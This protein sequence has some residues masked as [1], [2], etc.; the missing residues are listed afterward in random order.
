[1]LGKLLKDEMKSYRFPMG[2]VFLAGLV[3]TIFM[4]IMCMLP[5]DS[6]I[7]EGI[8]ILVA[9]GYYYIILLIVTAA[10]V[11]VIIRFYTTMVSDRGYLT[12]TLPIKS[13]THIWAKLISGSIWRLIAM[14]VTGM[15]L[16]VF[17]IG[18][19]WDID[20]MYV[21]H[22][23]KLAMSELVSGF[24]WE[25]I[26][27]IFFTIAAVILWS[28]TSVL[29]LYMCIAI[30]QLFGKWRL[31]A[32][33]GTYFVIMMIIY[34]LMMAGVVFLSIGILPFV[35]WLDAIIGDVKLNATLVLTGVIAIF[36]AVGGGLDALFFG[37]TNNIFKKHLNLE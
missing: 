12:W 26:P 5:Y 20:F 24:K 31:L 19:Y 33:I 22:D 16:F 28:V 6:S 23:I 30:G 25:Y 37:I 10:Q 3:F 29:M 27:A 32:S 8:Q 17:Y 14:I 34:A 11:L 35:E 13:S 1:M 21:M 4:K 9:Y 36:A 18:N 15:L 2:I 7:K